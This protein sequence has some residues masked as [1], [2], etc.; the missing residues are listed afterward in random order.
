MRKLALLFCL[1]AGSSFAAEEFHRTWVS[2]G[3]IANFATGSNYLTD[4]LASTRPGASAGFGINLTNHIA[5]ETGVDWISHPLGSIGAFGY[6]LNAG[7]QLYLVPFG[8]R[9]GF[10][11]SDGKW[12]LYAGGGGAFAR[13]TF[14]SGANILLNQTGFG[15]YGLAGADVGLGS[16]FRVGGQMRYYHLSQSRN[17]VQ[18]GLTPTNFITVGPQVTFTF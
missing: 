1:A 13:H 10:G 9:Y 6:S 7:D 3:F 17:L 8:A 16:H 12:R 18:L 15:G 11:P 5:V 2:G 4:A 14:P